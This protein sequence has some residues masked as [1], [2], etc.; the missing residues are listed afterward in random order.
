M[1]LNPPLVFKQ[2]VARA[3]HQLGTIK[4]AL[5]GATKKVK[6]H[7]CT[8]LC[9]PLVEYASS[10]WDPVLEYQIHHIEMAQ[11]RTVRFIC[12]LKSRVSISAAL[13]TLELDNLSER[14]NKSRHDLLLAILSNEECYEALSYS[15]EELMNT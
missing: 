7:A 12:D 4:Q 15:Y 11:H 14:H 8:T 6:L 5:Y 2:K 9:R 1:I 10:V 13:D 3:K